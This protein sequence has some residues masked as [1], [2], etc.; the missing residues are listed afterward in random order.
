MFPDDLFPEHRL[1]IFILVIVALHRVV[2]HALDVLNLDDPVE[3]LNIIQRVEYDVL[4]VQRVRVYFLEQNNISAADI[5]L[6]AVGYDRLWKNRKD[7]EREPNRDDSDNCR[8]DPGIRARLFHLL[9]FAA[10]RFSFADAA[11]HDREH[12]R[13]Q[14]AN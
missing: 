4:L 6:H 5:R 10:G 14:R 9:P 13:Q 11:Q 7:S 1:W 12:Q 8:R 2:L 3:Y